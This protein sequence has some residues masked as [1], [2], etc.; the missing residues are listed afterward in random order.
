MKYETNNI[1]II[2]SRKEL[3]TDNYR[4]GSP[5]PT[6]DNFYGSEKVLDDINNEKEETVEPPLIV[7]DKVKESICLLIKEIVS[8]NFL[9][10]VI[11]PGA[12]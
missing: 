7:V 11:S 5:V 1:Q 10:K 4:L 8:D 9:L 12:S 2:I 3:K 6:C